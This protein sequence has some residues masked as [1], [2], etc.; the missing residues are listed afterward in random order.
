LH[1][2][3][4]SPRQHNAAYGMAVLDSPQTWSI[5]NNFA[6]NLGPVFYELDSA[7]V[8]RGKVADGAEAE[9]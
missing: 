3:S 1:D 8:H 4:I 9:H 5:K 7:D 6:V 2:N